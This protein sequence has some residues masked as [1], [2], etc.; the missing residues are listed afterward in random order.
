MTGEPFSDATRY[1]ARFFSQ[2]PLKRFF[3]YGSSISPTFGYQ[4][5]FILFY[6]SSWDPTLFAKIRLELL[7]AH[8]GVY[9]C[10]ESFSRLSLRCTVLV[11]FLAFPHNWLSNASQSIP[12]VHPIPSIIRKIENKKLA[13]SSFSPHNK[14]PHIIPSSTLRRYLRYCPDALDFS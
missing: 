14:G 8:A 10:Y 2:T 1:P 3:K 5:P 11:C 9:C 12:K 4:T 7:D 13:V 6:R